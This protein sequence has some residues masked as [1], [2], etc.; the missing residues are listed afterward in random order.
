MKQGKPLITFVI[1]SMA[2]VIA[3]YAAAHLLDTFEEPYKTTQVYA[4]TADDSVLA[5]GLVV[6]EA[7]VLP[8]PSGILE[9][10]RAEGE[11]VGIGQQIALV[12]RDTE[13]Q[14]S[15]AQ[16]EEL[17]MDVA[18]LE[19]AVSQTGDLES[20]ARLDQDVLQAMVDLRAAYAQQNYN[21]LREQVMAVKSS[22]LKRGY[23]YGDGLTSADLTARLNKT[24][25]ELAVLTR[26]SARATTREIGRA[27]AEL[28]SQR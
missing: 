8:A 24:R 3:I 6:R 13:A 27:H 17:E 12:Y 11:K 18:L 5:E 2:A 28:Q 1:L 10:T 26:Q 22:V 20:A 19:E 25:E 23:T 21:Q 9:V 14:A 7:L 15:Q 16:I 4:Y